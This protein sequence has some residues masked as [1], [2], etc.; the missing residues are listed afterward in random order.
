[1][2]G[3]SDAPAAAP[4]VRVVHLRRGTAPVRRLAV[5]DLP[6]EP[7]TT[8]GDP[9]AAPEG[10]PEAADPAGLTLDDLDPEVRA[11]LTRAALD[12]VQALADACEGEVDGAEDLA[13]F[14]TLDHQGVAEVELRAI[15][16]DPGPIEV[17]DRALPDALVRC[18]D[19]T[20]WDQDW[21]VAGPAVP[22]GSELPV[23][24]SLRLQAP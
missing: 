10:A 16:A 19:D 7:G 13:A 5:P 24:L 17:Q 15:G 14:V 8:D 20:V 6:A 18:L 23:A 9:D 3:R 1:A 12:R 4:P 22:E 2:R 11:T 21:S